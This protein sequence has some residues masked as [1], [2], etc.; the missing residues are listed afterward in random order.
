MKKLFCLILALTLLL[1][2]CTGK[3]NETTVPTTEATVPTSEETTDVTTTPTDAMIDPTESV[4]GS[5]TDGN[6]STGDSNM[7]RGIFGG[8]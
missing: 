5:G 7:A 8:R 4:G 2:G 3:Q 1:C 6:P